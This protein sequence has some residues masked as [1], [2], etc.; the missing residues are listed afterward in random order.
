MFLW[1]EPKAK[2]V[3]GLEQH[4]PSLKGEGDLEDRR[5]SFSMALIGMRHDHLVDGGSAVVLFDVRRQIRHCACVADVTIAAIKVRSVDESRTN[6][7]G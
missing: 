5:K 4:K 7:E 2:T 6:D 3:C 1:E